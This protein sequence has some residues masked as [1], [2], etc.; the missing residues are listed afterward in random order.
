MTTEYV[1]SEYNFI[2]HRWVDSKSY[3]TQEEAESFFSA[4]PRNGAFEMWLEDVATG[5]I[6]RMIHR[7]EKV[8][9]DIAAEQAAARRRRDAA[10]PAH[11]GD[12]YD[13]EAACSASTLQLVLQQEGGPFSGV[14]GGRLASARVTLTDQE[15]RAVRTRL[16]VWGD[17][18]LTRVFSKAGRS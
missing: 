7:S 3:P 13:V 15:A 8:Q 10:R 5:G 11:G 16:A 12:L 9:R 18:R 17:V 6:V 1:V 14:T 4:Q 2:T